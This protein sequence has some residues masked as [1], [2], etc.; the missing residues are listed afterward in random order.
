MHKNDIAIKTI[1]LYDN[2]ELIAKSNHLPFE[3]MKE[4]VDFFFNEYNNTE[5]FDDLFKQTLSDLFDRSKKKDF[6]K[7]LD[8]INIYKNS[9]NIE[10]KKN[11]V[12][13]SCKII[14]D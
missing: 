9:Y 10:I 11:K 6:K 14:E 8:Y 7:I 4:N 5:Y 13:Y 3:E 2:K 12:Q 1:N